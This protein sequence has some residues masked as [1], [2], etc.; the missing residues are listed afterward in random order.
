MRNSIEFIIP[1]MVDGGKKQKFRY[2]GGHHSENLSKEWIDDN[3]RKDFEDTYK[4]LVSNE[5][6]E[7][8]IP[9]P[10]G[11]RDDKEEKIEEKITIPR[12][13]LKKGKVK[14]CFGESAYCAFGNV[15]N[16]LHLLKDDKAASFFFINRFKKRLICSKDIVHCQRTNGIL[17]NLLVLFGYFVKNLD[18]QQKYLK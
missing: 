1:T 15:A 5:Y 17:M 14:Y 13:Y 8:K 10:T 6:L 3:F 4:L 9:C 11:K 16:T 12:H 7:K 2:K 18:I